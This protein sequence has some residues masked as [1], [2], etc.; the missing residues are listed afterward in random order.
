MSMKVCVLGSSSSGNST[1][2]ASG[3]TRILIDAGLSYRKLSQR[4][5][6][7]GEDITRLD[8]VCVTHEHTDHTCAIPVLHK[9][10]GA[11]L[12]SN[13]GTVDGM[14]GSDRHRGLPW[15]VFTTGQSFQVGDL[16]LD[17]F[18]VPHDAYD[19]VG[20]TV[21]CAGTTVGI[22]TDMGMTTELIR[23]RL[24]ACRVVVV[25]SNHDVELLKS[26]S[27][28]WSLKQRISGRHGHLSNEQAAELLAEIA[29]GALETVFLAHLSAEC[30][31][32]EV[33]LR[34]VK[35]ALE[36]DTSIAIDVKL[37]YSER[38]SDVVTID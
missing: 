22:V 7:I 27:R 31:R 32:P 19:P 30:N 5:E 18:S 35:R 1:F 11:S 33:A 12:F 17:P 15:Q 36:K 2:V 14:K 28:P 21:Q 9:R 26:A 6:S 13:S 29:G 37:T 24:R 20:F 23:Q 38:P 4:L 25:E 8:A 16:L 3:T 34:D 10:T